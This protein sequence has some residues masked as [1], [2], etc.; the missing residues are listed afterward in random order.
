MSG[1]PVAATLQ[2]GA[3]PEDRDLT[4]KARAARP[5][6]RWWW[7][8]RKWWTPVQ[9]EESSPFAVT[10]GEGGWTVQSNGAWCYLCDRPI[11]TWSSRWPP[12]EQAKA[13]IALHRTLHIQ[14]RLDAPP[15]AEE[16]R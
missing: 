10:D 7:G 14:E 16:T 3:G 4:I 8:V 5:G 1:T 9:S 15:T 6:V 12:T 11:A 13:R 2:L